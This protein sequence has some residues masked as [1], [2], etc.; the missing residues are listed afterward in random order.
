ML[1]GKEQMGRSVDRKVV[2]EVIILKD[3][4]PT[5]LFKFYHNMA[6]IHGLL[7]LMSMNPHWYDE[8]IFKE[9]K[10]HSTLDFRD[11]KVFFLKKRFVYK[12]PAILA[13]QFS[14]ELCW[15]EIIFNGVN[16]VSFRQLILQFFVIFFIETHT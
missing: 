3:F 10:L 6:L 11:F 9:P 15:I 13:K 8:R 14:P 5:P 4:N 16:G 2:Q 12:K 7:I 1:I